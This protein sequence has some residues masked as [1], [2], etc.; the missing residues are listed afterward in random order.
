MHLAVRVPLVRS[1]DRIVAG[2]SSPLAA[3][4][5]VPRLAV[6]IALV[7]LAVSGFGV[8]F[9]MLAWALMPGTDTASFTAPLSARFGPRDW[10]DLGAL[11]AISAGITQ[12][13]AIAGIGLPA[14]IAI[15]LVLGVA[16]LIL[17]LSLPA[18]V[19]DAGTPT[20]SVTLPSWVPPGA[21]AAVDVLGT[22]RALL[23]RVVVGV[24]FVVGGLVV[25]LTASG[26]WSAVRTGLLAVGAILIGLALGFGPWLWRL[27]TELVT[28]RRE[29]IRSDERA[30]V[31]A[32]L[33]DSVLQTLAMVQRRADDPR[34]VVRLARQQERELRSWLLSGRRSEG[35]AGTGSVRAALAALGAELEDTNGV[36]VEMVQVRDC[37]LGPGLAALLDATREAISNAQRH[38][39]ATRVSVYC[40]VGADEVTV[41]VRD[42]GNGFDRSRIAPDRRGIAE[43][44]EGRMARRGGR[45]AVRTTPGSGTEVELAMPRTTA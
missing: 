44:I 16:G 40:E 4:L 7:A 26:S 33:H 3:F 35:G 27:G 19:D 13:F 30:E 5:H 11:A 28:E 1:D 17:L 37:E 45:A 21:A 8:V 43:S 24:C 2:V 23:A 32:H 18:S 34:E 9:Y 39:G 36:P 41:Y 20:R 25:L 15:P 12:L 42:R 10:V 6:R 29:R 38:S 31:A 14:R 22:R